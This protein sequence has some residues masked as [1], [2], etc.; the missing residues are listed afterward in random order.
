MSAAT[1]SKTVLS[2]PSLRRRPPRPAELPNWLKNLPFLLLHLTPLAIL[3][4]GTDV[5][6][7]VLCGVCYLIHMVGI[8]AGYHRY[9]SHRSYKTSRAFQFVLACLG[10]SA[11][12]KGPLWW[13]AQHRHHH[14]HSDT[15][16][17]RHSPVA[18]SLWWS[19]IGWVLS[20]ESVATDE[21]T[22][23]DLSRYPELRWLDRYHGVPPLALAGLCLL[24][25]GWSGL[26]WGFF[27]S[28]LLSHHASFLVNSLCHLVGRRRYATADASRNNVL[29]ALLTLGEGWHNNHHHY[30]SSANQGFFWWEV[31]IT[32]YLIR[33]L[34][35]LGLVW[36]V[37]KP[38]RAK[39]LAHAGQARTPPLPPARPTRPEPFRPP[40]PGGGRLPGQ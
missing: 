16:A 40:P 28:S 37:R 27:V 10:C 2:G 9:F 34:A 7:L 30:Q 22:V 35:C 38:P 29:V 6:A 39:L 31:D 8:T 20:T 33:L 32:Y 11:L 19:H 1:M 25:G 17:D 12:Q 24:L 18:H 5:R 15:P 23:Q 3:W 26:V 21:R 36:D 4:T 13:A 14:R